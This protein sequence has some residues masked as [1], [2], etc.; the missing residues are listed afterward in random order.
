MIILR[1]ILKVVDWALVGLLFIPGIL[2]FC[3][4][5]GFIMV[6]GSIS[7]TIECWTKWKR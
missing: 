6:V 7:T 2:L 4:Y 1:H 5:V 3:F